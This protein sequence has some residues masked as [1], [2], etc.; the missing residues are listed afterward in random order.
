V[1]DADQAMTELQRI[2]P[3]P[4]AH[5]VG[6]DELQLAA[7]HR[8]LRPA[9]ARI[10]PAGLRPD[11]LAEA[12]EVGERRRCYSAPLDGV[13]DAEL[14]EFA[15]RRG[16]K[17]DAAAKR[18]R[19]AAPVVEADGGLT[20][21]VKAERGGEPADA[22]ADDGD[23]HVTPSSSRVVHIVLWANSL[24]STGIAP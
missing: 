16:K 15:R 19:L 14:G 17:V 5:G 3:E 21:G 1:I 18:A 7:M 8:D 22:G 9:V 10:A 13:A 2:G 12:V 11:R 4:V 23:P 6:E 20:G 24:L